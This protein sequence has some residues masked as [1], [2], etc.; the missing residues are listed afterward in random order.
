MSQAGVVVVA[1]GRNEG[2]RL[3]RCLA[4]LAGQAELV[5][6]VDSGST[7]GSRELAASMGAE[8][9]ALDMSVPF[10]AARARNAGFQR[11]RELAPSAA[12]VQFIDGD[13][14]LRSQWL[15][16]AAAF[17]AAHAEVAAVCGRRRER[18]PERSVYNLLCDVEWAV[19]PG[20]ARSCGGDAMFRSAALADV[21]GYNPGMIAGEEPELCVRLR[22]RGWGVQVL[23]VEM[24]LHDANMLR[25]SQWWIRSVRSGYAY[26]EGAAL[27]GGPPERHNVRELMRCVGWGLVLPLLTLLGLALWGPSAAWLLALYPAQALRLFIQGNG[28]W[29]TRLL[30]ATFLGIGK[31]AEVTGALRYW[32]LRL[33]K[34]RATLIEYK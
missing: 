31:F 21:G 34:R 3:R 6:Y 23:A 4:S 20:P 11:G 12:C 32:R 24:T 19:P 27:H 9:V 5:V 18:H 22:Q 15:A 30:R 2:E 1:I 7:D 16:T 14:E 13:C 26:A 8:V 29:R 17:M 25:F 10:T 28:T 33:L